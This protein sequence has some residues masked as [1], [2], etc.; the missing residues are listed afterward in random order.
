[1]NTIKKTTEKEVIDLKKT[2]ARLEKKIL[3][4][5]A[6]INKKQDKKFNL[7][8]RRR[9]I[10]KNIASFFFDTLP[11]DSPLIKTLKSKSVF[12]V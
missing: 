4:M 3:L 2:V 9:A 6:E 12:N 10:H 5:Q 11:A 8:I 1:M 7:R